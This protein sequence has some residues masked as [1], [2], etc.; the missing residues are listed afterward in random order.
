MKLTPIKI[1]GKAGQKTARGAP[2][3]QHYRK[4][5]RSDSAMSHD[6]VDAP[7]H[8]RLKTKRPAALIEQLPTEILERITIMSQNLNFPRSSLRLGYIL[9]D[10]SFLT[11]VLVTAFG[12]T[13]DLWFG[14]LLRNIFAHCTFTNG[15]PQFGGDPAFQ[16]EVLACPW[17]NLALLLEAQQKWCRTAGTQKFFEHVDPW[18]LSFSLSPE[19][20][21]HPPRQAHPCKD[22]A[23]CFEAD[24]E[25][26]HSAIRGF[27]SSKAVGTR[28]FEPTVHGS[29]WRCGGYLDIHPHAKIPER[30]LCNP[31][32][33]DD[34]RWLFWFARGGSRLSGHTWEVTKCGYEQIMGLADKEL[35]FFLLF[36]FHRLG[37]FS[38]QHWPA[39]LAEKKQTEASLMH[40]DIVRAGN[41]PAAAHVWWL[42]RQLLRMSIN[43]IGSIRLAVQ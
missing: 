13:W 20:P 4:R 37:V 40:Q 1:K 8:R 3:T 39:F 35:A 10:R 24:W 42:A 43:I 29:F 23:A 9:S 25:L 5:G 32:G 36:L 12:G 30:L 38:W 16:S 22:P 18:P 28:M 6:N 34:A 2:K 19:S 27:F 11:D 26:V 33:W 41:D 15:Y 21:D 31:V 14:R 17:M 7:R